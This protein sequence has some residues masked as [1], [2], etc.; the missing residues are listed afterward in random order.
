MRILTF[1]HSFEPGGVE[2]D[3][4][5]LNDAWARLGA[6]VQIVLGRR[7]GR[8]AD[9]APDLPY[10]VLQTGSISTAAFET[11]WM[12][13]KLPAA[14]R[15]L[16]PD[17]LFCS[18]N[19]YSIVAVA[20]RLILG[21]RC[22]PIILRV[23]NDLRR[24]DLPAVARWFYRRWLRLQM[25]VFDSVVAMADP[26]F[27]EIA[28]EMRVP[29]NRI[30]VINNG[31]IRAAEALA[32]AR[33]RDS[34]KRDA[35]A[36]RTFLA[37]GRLVAQKNFSL[38]LDAFAR[39]AGPADRLMIVGAGPENANIRAQAQRLGIVGQLE[40]PG[41]VNPL[42]HYFAR[43]HAY[44]LSS[45]YEGLPAVLIESLAAGVP[46]IATDCCASV[47]FLVEGAGRVVAPRD[48]AAL[49]AAME[50]IGDDNFNAATARARAARFTVEATAPAWIS[51]LE[52]R[53]K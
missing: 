29:T 45:N 40:M 4:L 34:A 13:A 12:I 42:D 2:R 19:T 50:R 9:E 23:S 16:K 1:L 41:H 20:M 33:A 32:L 46:I 22:P 6:D 43:A 31:S 15:Q 8:L 47:K 38:L 18:G 51:L 37:V 49:A 10:T 25:P 17:I 27:D 7:D 21:R 5:R 11:L 39:M 53:R 28:E 35:A 26:L 52:A 3:A 30:T 36:G 14:I 44:V 24:H 48:V